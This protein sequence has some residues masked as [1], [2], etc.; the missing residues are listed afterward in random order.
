[1]TRP[2]SSPGRGIDV[3]SPSGITSISVC[4]CPR[5]SDICESFNGKLRN[6]LL[7]EE[8]F[9]TLKEAQILTALWRRERCKSGRTARWAIRLRPGSR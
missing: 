5:R 4:R 3:S 8:I 9:Y 7:N 6:G 2:G 1:M